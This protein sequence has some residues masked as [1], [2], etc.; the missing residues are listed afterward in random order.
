[1]RLWHYE[2][3]EYLPDKQL[4]GQWRECVCIAKNIYEKGTPNHILVNRIMNYNINHF[5]LYCLLVMNHLISRGFHIHIDAIN[6]LKLYIGFLDD[7]SN[8]P[9]LKS[10]F[11]GWHSKEYS[12]I[13]M[14]NLYEKYACNGMT[15]S[16][17]ARLEEGFC[18]S[19]GFYFTFL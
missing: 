8:Y 16:E 7:N 6:K 13:C 17:W 12:Q 1:M 18:N 2:L 9:T 15:D 10:L 14:S 3:L 11:S 5:R 19:F 4:R